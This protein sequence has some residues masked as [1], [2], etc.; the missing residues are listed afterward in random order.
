MAWHGIWAIP[1]SWIQSA[2]ELKHVFA[3]G[4]TGCAVSGR[5]HCPL[6]HPEPEP[7]P[8]HDHDS[9]SE[10]ED[11]NESESESEGENENETRQHCG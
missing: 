11:A 9:E 2:G 6:P 10:S 5:I 7:E 3:L 8:D 1:A 4:V